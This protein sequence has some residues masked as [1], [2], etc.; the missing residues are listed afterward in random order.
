L[1]PAG[2]VVAQRDRPLLAVGDGAHALARNAARH[3]IFAH[4]L[5]AA[6]AERDI[7][8]TRAALV[9]MAFDRESVAIVIGQPLRLLVERRA[10]LIGQL[11]RVGFEEN[12]V[13]DIDDK[14]LLAAGDRGAGQG[15]GVGLFGAARDRKRRQNGGSEFSAAQDCRDVHSGAL[16][17][18]RGVQRWLARPVILSR[19]SSAFVKRRF[20]QP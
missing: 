1:R 7:I 9:G 20:R 4:G 3:Q 13:T 17:K 18:F 6:S 12:A 8:F 2:D 5:G 15:T 14:V 19:S 11:G 10:R 16:H